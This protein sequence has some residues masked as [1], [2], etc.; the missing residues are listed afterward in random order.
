MGSA[1]VLH[2]EALR[3]Y[4]KPSIINVHTILCAGCRQPYPCTTIRDLD[5]KARAEAAAGL[6]IY[7][8]YDDDCTNPYTPWTI[9]CTY[10]K[11]E[12]RILHFWASTMDQAY[13]QAT[14]HLENMHSEESSSSIV[15]VDPASGSPLV[16]LEQDIWITLK[17]EPINNS[18]YD[19]ITIKCS[20]HGFLSSTTLD[21]NE[22]IIK[23]STHFEIMHPELPLWVKYE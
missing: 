10:C 17:K 13:W 5:S 6:T 14:F 11:A 18:V 3:S 12:G 7:V 9:A 21:E 23:A 22:M 20:K 1:L 16:P 15:K 8:Y 19:M 2:D 4:H